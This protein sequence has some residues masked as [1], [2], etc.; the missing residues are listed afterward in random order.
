[1]IK[2]VFL[3]GKVVK[4]A[5]DVRKGHQRRI[6]D[7]EKKHSVSIRSHHDTCTRVALFDHTVDPRHLAARVDVILAV[8]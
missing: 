6:Q 1:M 3:S 2:H 7:L 8:T 5:L 4:I